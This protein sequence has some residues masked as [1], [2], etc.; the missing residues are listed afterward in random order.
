MRNTVQRVCGRCHTCQV[1]K[2]HMSRLGLLPPKDP[3]VIPWEKLCINLIGPY[4]IGKGKKEIT[5]HCLTMIDPATRWF[6]I[7]EVPSKSADEIANIL[8]QTWL[9]RYPW[10]EQVIMDRGKE[11]MAEV[12]AM[13]C[14]DYGV[15][16][17]PITT[18]NPQANAMVE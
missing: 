15:T 5:L 11:F 7:T 13:L 14:D 4:T 8:E 6:E 18:R 17:K 9:T 2:N 3:E 10:P 12:K 16:H 1:Q